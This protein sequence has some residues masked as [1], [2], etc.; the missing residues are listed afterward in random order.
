[1]TSPG[2]FRAVLPVQ[3]RPERL[4]RLYDSDPLRD[5]D[6]IGVPSTLPNPLN[7]ILDGACKAVERFRF[8]GVQKHVTHDVLAE[9]VQL[10]DHEKQSVVETQFV[11]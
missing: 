6:R 11:L 8:L 5:G 10:V 7:Q 3:Q 9:R 2:T 4:G 1:M